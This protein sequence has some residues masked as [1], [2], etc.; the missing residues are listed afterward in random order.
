MAWL[1]ATSSGEVYWL[2]PL[3]LWTCHLCPLSLTLVLTATPFLLTRMPGPAPK[4]SELM[5]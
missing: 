3:L 2:I 1:T 5:G 4:S